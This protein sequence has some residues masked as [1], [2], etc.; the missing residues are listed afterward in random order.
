MKIARSSVGMIILLAASLVAQ[1]LS[2]QTLSIQNQS[3]QTNDPAGAVFAATN[4][5]GQNEIVMYS[6][7]ARGHLRLVGRFST[8]G[9]GEGGLND[10][11]QSQSSLIVSSDHNYL[12]AVN[13]GTSDI[14]VFRITPSGLLLLSVTPSGGGNPISIA[15]YDDLVYVVNF[16]GNYHTAG[17]RL[18]PWG[19]LMPVANSKQTFAALDPGVSTVAFTPDGSKLVV[20]E[21]LT[22][23]I[24]V[25]TVNG[26]GSLSNPVSNNSAGVEPFG[27][28][29]N[30]NGT[31]LVSETEGGPPNE[32]TVSSYLVN[33]DNTLTVISPKAGAGGQATCWVTTYG[34]YAYG[35]NTASSNI[36]GYQVG[37]NGSLTALGA[38]AQESAPANVATSFPLD[39]TFSSDGKFLYVFY[40]GL[41]EIAGYAV[42]SNG[43][44][45]KITNAYPEM[46]STG[47]EGLAAY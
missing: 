37:A 45:S 43:Q 2:G 26:D 41:G 44:L 38:V 32:G 40:S 11:L 6:R 19:G 27:I 4:G 47:A 28:E 14:S 24:D 8:G 46:P 36:G 25:F 13:S 23:K 33:S 29:F 30:S 17:F 10:P 35:S 5:A 34:S 42:A 3:A 21:R 9:R 22:N 12:L 18:A 31:L 7:G 20:T 16:G 15:M 1:A 39:L